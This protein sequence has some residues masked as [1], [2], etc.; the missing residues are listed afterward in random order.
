RSHGGKVTLQELADYYRDDVG[1]PFQVRFVPDRRST[2]VAVSPTGPRPPLPADDP[3]EATIVLLGT[4]EDGKLSKE[5]LAAAPTVLLRH[6]LNDDEVVTAQ[7]ILGGSLDTGG[8]P[9]DMTRFGSGPRAR[10]PCVLIRPGE[11]GSTL[12]QA[13]RTRYGLPYG[14]RL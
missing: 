9:R 5:E 8:I 2:P 14:T 6:D 10:S 12:A 7:E 3:D 4:N 11:P 1:A 13:L